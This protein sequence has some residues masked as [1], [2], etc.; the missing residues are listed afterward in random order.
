ML[1]TAS[2]ASSP[3]YIVPQ[4]A[5]ADPV[6]LVVSVRRQ[7]LNYYRRF[8]GDYLRDTAHLTLEQHGAYNLL[9]DHLYAT[10]KP[11]PS[12]EAALRICH[13]VTRMRPGRST[14]GQ[15]LVKDMLTNFFIETPAGFTHKRFEEE[16]SYSEAR[17][18]CARQSAEARWKRDAN[19][20]RT[21]CDGNAL[22]TPDTR[23]QTPEVLSPSKNGGAEVQERPPES[24]EM[25][26]VCSG[27]MQFCPVK[28][29]HTAS[30]RRKALEAK[31][32]R[33]RYRPRFTPAA[34]PGAEN[35]VREP[36]VENQPA[37]SKGEERA[38]RTRKALEH[39]GD[40]ARLPKHLRPIV[41][42]GNNK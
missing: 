20:M 12:F 27:P 6:A 24:L 25:C 32:P 13:I 10:E 5:A 15:K 19:A 18:N 39:L 34:L 4:G 23:V 28:G 2:K 22:Q 30:A 9:L 11:I 42:N 21:Q 17:S 3:A 31:D 26:E 16:L 29:D 7:N 8:P 36:Y 41:P 14:S 35:Y 33:A 37:R 40:P 1:R 38:E